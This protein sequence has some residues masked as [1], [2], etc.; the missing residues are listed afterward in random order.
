MSV[1]TSV[2]NQIIS[3]IDK[4]NPDAKLLIVSKNRTIEDIQTLVN[5]RYFKFGE[6]RVQEAKRKFF[7]FLLR[8]KLELHLIGRLQSN[9]VEEALKIFDVI[10]SIDRKKIVDE[11]VKLK[12]NF[13]KIRTKSFFIQVNL[14]NEVQKS[15][16]NEIDLIELYK[17]CLKNQINISGLMCIPPNDHDPKRF[18]MKMNELKKKIDPKL[19]LSMGMSGD[20]KD[21][22]ITGSNLIRVGSII[23]ND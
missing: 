4:L 22:L 17:Y 19:I 14:G 6:N 20:Y 16:V 23:F 1:N 7:N 11:I 21:A 8:D 3:D 18:F 9:K 10:Q 12:N 13:K 5:L 15:G 2:I